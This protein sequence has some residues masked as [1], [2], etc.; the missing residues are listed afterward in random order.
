MYD[1]YGYGYGYDMTS[2]GTRVLCQ[3]MGENQK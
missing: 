2:Y 1:D 3:I